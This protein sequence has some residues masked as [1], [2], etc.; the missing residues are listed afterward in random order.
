MVTETK[1]SSLK[2]LSILNLKEKSR[3]SVLARIMLQQSTSHST[4]CRKP[5]QINMESFDPIEQNH[6]NKETGR[7]RWKTMKK[8]VLTV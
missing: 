3:T 5:F 7:K 2:A 1:I 4:F 8:K 6:A